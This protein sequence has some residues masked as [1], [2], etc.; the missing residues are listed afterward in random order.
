M[1]AMVLSPGQRANLYYNLSTLT[2]SGVPLLRALRVAA[3]NASRRQAGLILGVE[4]DLRKG[5]GLAETLGQRMGSAGRLDAA[6][7]GSAEQ[8]GN[9]D[10]AFKML[11]DW[12][13]FRH[14]LH[15]KVI[16][17]LIYP[18]GILHI[19]VLIFFLP[20]LVL[21]HISA[22]GYLLS[23]F[24]TLAG[25]YLIAVFSFGLKAICSR[26][27]LMSAIIV[28]ASLLVPIIGRAVMDLAVC[29]FGQCLGMMYKAGVPLD[30]ALRTCAD[31]AGPVLSPT[32]HKAADQVGAGC[33]PTD[34]LE[35]VIPRE[36]LEI[37][38]VGEQSGQLDKAL[39]RIAKISGDRAESA[40]GQMAIWLPRLV[41]LLVVTYVASMILRLAGQIGSMYQ[42]PLE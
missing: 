3:A 9:L 13:Q 14:N 32:I 1:I 17:G 4:Q 41:Y 42:M 27:R 28:R 24:G 2:G 31:V 11:A 19:A 30:H 29:R 23:V 15:N 21:G 7:V 35:G 6:V 16:T 36:Y 5:L 34:V 20:R 12:Y 18:V 10:E 26:S 38:L 37:W 8:T 39:E 25:F 40:I 33:Q 22:F